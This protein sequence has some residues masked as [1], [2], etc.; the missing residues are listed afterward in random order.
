MWNIKTNF[1]LERD[2]FKSRMSNKKH[3]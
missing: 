2:I 3:F 1:M